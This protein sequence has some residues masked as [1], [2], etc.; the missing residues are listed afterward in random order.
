MLG[1]ICYLHSQVRLYTSYYNKIGYWDG[2][3]YVFWGQPVAA[4]VYKA[5][6][7]YCWFAT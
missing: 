6:S 4:I 5:R 2:A 7:L 3:L 1:T